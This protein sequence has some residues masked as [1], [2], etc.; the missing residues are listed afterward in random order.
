MTWRGALRMAATVTLMAGILAWL[1]P[2]AVLAEVTHLEPGWAILGLALTLPPLLLSA[3]RWRFTA[4][5]LGLALGR[6]QAVG[7]YYLASFLNQLVPGAWW[8]MPCVRGG[9]G[10]TMGARARPGARW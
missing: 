8:V 4:T 9:M 2:A 5:C 1:D 3:W 6:R 7:E 10:G